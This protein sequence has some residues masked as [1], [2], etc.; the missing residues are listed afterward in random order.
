M[1]ENLLLKMH[2]SF[3]FYTITFNSA[4]RALLVIRCLKKSMLSDVIRKYTILHFLVLPL[5]RFD[6]VSVF[7]LQMRSFT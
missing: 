5:L 6:L 2:C 4:S 1:I 7:F 3:C